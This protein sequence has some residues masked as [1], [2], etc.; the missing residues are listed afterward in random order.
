MRPGVSECLKLKLCVVFLDWKSAWRTR[1]HYATDWKAQITYWKQRV[2]KELKSEELKVT[3]KTWD[4]LE[5]TCL[6]LNR[7]QEPW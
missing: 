4:L 1:S 6:Q 2:T 3:G 7:Q 5:V